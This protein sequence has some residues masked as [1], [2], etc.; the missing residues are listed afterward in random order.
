MNYAE[1][2]G[3]VLSR[4][5][6]SPLVRKP[7]Q[8]LPLAFLFFWIIYPKFFQSQVE[9]F[10]FNHCFILLGLGVSYKTTMIDFLCTSLTSSAAIFLDSTKDS[11]FSLAF[12][13]SFWLRPTGGTCTFF[14]GACLLSSYLALPEHPPIPTTTHTPLLAHGLDLDKLA[15]AVG[16]MLCLRAI[17]YLS[18]LI[19]EHFCVLF[20]F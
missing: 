12:F 15:L 3:L 6:Y 20:S 17:P 5:K 18:F 1:F 10:P 2:A 16:I 13:Y 7:S 4:F 14:Q 8:N 11:V 19:P 9:L